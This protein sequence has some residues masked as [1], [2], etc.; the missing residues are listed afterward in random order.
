M[1]V[2]DNTDSLDFKLF[3]NRHWGGYHFPRHW[4]LSNPATM[5]RLAEKTETEVENLAT[6][7]SPVNWVYSIRNRLTDKKAPARL[8]ERSRLKSPL[9]L[10]I[11]TVFDI[12]NNLCGRGALLNAILK[13][14]A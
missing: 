11:F 1:I 10:G 8:I 7:V 4:N 6:Q 14:P 12:L 13:R 2:T 5:R 9:S 3:K